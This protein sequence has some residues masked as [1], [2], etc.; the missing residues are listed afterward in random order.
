MELY[1]SFLASLLTEGAMEG[2]FTDDSLVSA[3]IASSAYSFG[4]RLYLPCNPLVWRQ[5]QQC[6]RNSGLFMHALRTFSDQYV[7]WIRT[8]APDLISV[9]LSWTYQH[10]DS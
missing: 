5:L 1:G 7:V 8:V 6:Y 4:A 3:V 9:W 2:I 10:V